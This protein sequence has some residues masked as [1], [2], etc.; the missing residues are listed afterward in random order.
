MN[1]TQRNGNWS[2]VQR[3]VAGKHVEL[4][5]ARYCLSENTIERTLVHLREGGEVKFV[6]VKDTYA[7]PISAELYTWLGTSARFR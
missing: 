3:Y 2:V 1:D 5:M 7:S 4:Q 6:N